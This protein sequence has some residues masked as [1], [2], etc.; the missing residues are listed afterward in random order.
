MKVSEEK[1]KIFICLYHCQNRGDFTPLVVRYPTN[2]F[3]EAQ[4]S[5]VACE[6]PTLEGFLEIILSSF[7]DMEKIEKIEGSR[8]DCHYLC[9]ISL[10]D[11]D[12]KLYGDIRKQQLV[13]AQKVDE[14]LTKETNFLKF[15]YE[16]VEDLR[17][18]WW[19]VLYSYDTSGRGK[20]ESP[21]WYPS[22]LITDNCD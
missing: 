12:E 17:E 7:L 20:R 9:G 6:H 3:Y 5:A 16:N 13:V 21:H 18:G 10:A 22:I 14:F 1:N 19:P 11:Y 15:D 8:F 2:V 4:T